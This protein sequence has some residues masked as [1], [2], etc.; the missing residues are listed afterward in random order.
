ML[1]L[2]TLSCGYGDMRAVHGLDLELVEGGT[3][4]LLGAN[5][6]GKSSTIMSV[7][8][9]VQVHEGKVLYRGEDITRATPMARV[10]K[11]IAVVPEGRRL[12][13]S[14]TVRENLV[15]GG[16]SLPKPKSDAGIDR[17]MTLFPRLKER[18]DQRA[19]SLSGG[20]QQMLS[21]GRALMSEPALLMV[22]ELSLG[23]MPKMIDA[24]YQAVAE[25]KRGGLT[26]LLVEQSTHRALEVADQVCVLES[27]RSVWKGSA[28][29]ARNDTEIIDAL[30]GLQAGPKA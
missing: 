14:L 23:L 19:G 12:F 10:K 22:D 8:G 4:A 16:Y 28:H 26:I 9:H 6:A 27:G 5:G 24:C 29:E 11:G 15:V 13:S 17:V 18:L 20:E 21:I 25:L 30:L 7:A 1:R 2:E 3:T